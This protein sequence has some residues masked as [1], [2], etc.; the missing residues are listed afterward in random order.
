[1]NTTLRRPHQENYIAFY[2]RYVYKTEE[3]HGKKN[4]EHAGKKIKTK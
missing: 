1:M 4:Y 2:F 3:D